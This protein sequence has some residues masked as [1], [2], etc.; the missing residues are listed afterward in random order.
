V[1]Q[2][3]REGSYEFGADANAIILRTG[4]ATNANFSKGVA[5]FIEPIR[6]AMV[7]ASVGGQ[8]IKVTM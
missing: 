1:L 4:A 3:M 2:K 7:N 5:V 6:G 8:R